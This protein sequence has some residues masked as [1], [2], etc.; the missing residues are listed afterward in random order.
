MSVPALDGLV[1]ADSQELRIRVDGL[2]AFWT[3]VQITITSGGFARVG[4][5]SPEP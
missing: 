5:I 3:R 1:L 4:V 2:A